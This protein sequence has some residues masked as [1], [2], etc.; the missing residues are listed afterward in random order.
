MAVS[1]SGT[2]SDPYIP[3][4]FGDFLSVCGQENK[5]VCLQNDIDVS[6]DNVYKTGIT[7]PLNIRATIYGTAMTYNSSTTYN[8]GDKC[9]WNDGEHGLCTYTCKVDG[10]VGIDVSD[11]THWT[12]GGS[13][14]KKITGL[15]ITANSFIIY[16]HYQY[17]TM[18]NIFFESC[19]FFSTGG[20]YSTFI[21]TGST[22]HIMI[23]NDCIFSVFY[24]QVIG[25]NAPC[26][27]EYETYFNRCSL[28][29][30][31]NGP[32]LSNVSYN[33]YWRIISTTTY[34][35]NCTVDIENIS[36]LATG[37]S[38][39]QPQFGNMTSCS[40][41]MTCNA[42]SGT[43]SRSD[44]IFK[45]SNC[46]FVLTAMNIESEQSYTFKPTSSLTGVNIIDY[47]AVGNAT[48][49][50][51]ANLIQGTTAQCKDKDWLIS[52]GFFAS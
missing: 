37:S 8:T 22:N 5:Y 2:I 15:I 46:F 29:F 26:L 14:I 41:R 13:P 6:K 30:R 19:A 21:D 23:F 18:S 45:G 52:Q 24:N 51:H 50:P 42:Y 28:Y 34:M 10:T 12:R 7:S 44:I 16:Y 49:T 9:T 1:G 36:I 33:D 3:V 40:F 20:R 39:S 4:T 35:N 43:A 11:S 25:T 27:T 47:E 31:F 48:I 17:T 38:D 32:D